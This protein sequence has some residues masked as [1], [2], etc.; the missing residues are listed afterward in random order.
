M[1]ESADSKFRLVKMDDTASEHIN[2]P[3]YSY[4]AA[5]FKKFLS[6][7]STIVIMVIALTV[8]FLSVF[9][10]IIS[11]YDPVVHQNINNASMKFLHPSLKYLFGTND[12]GDNLWN[13]VWMGARNS[14]GIAFMATAITTTLGVVVGAV[15]GYSKSMDKWMLEIYNIVANVPFTLVVFVLMYVMGRG[16]WQL[17]FAMSVTSWLNTAYFIRV[18]V[19][20]IRDRE[21]NL[22]SRCLGTST[23]NIVKNNILP[24]LISVI[25]TSV[26]R[27]VPSFISM[28]VFL[29]WLGIGVGEKTPSLGKTISGNRTFMTNTP[30]LF[31]IPVAVSAVITISLYV[32]GQSLADAADP[33]THM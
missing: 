16:I 18:Q 15:W 12:L 32:A 6:K 17:I 26:S 20:I 33:R 29:A 23:W 11:G 1:M 31:W 22:A 4:W 21:Y 30:Y 8:I 2:A 19:L 3:K 13:V 14:L 10:P 25:V 9:D 28:E 7:K 5:V 24:Y 27:D